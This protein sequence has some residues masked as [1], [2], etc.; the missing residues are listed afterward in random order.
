RMESGDYKGCTVI[1]LNDVKGLPDEFKGMKETIK[2]LI[3]SD[4]TPTY[5]AK[6]IAFHM[7]KFGII[8]NTFRFGTFIEKQPNGKPILET[9]SEG[10]EM[11]LANADMSINIIDVRQSY[12]QAVLKLAFKGIGRDDVADGIRHLAYGEVELE[13]G[14]LSGR[15]GT[16]IGFSADDLLAEARERSSKLIK[17][18]FNF[19]DEEQNRISAS[20][21]LAAIKFE[22]MRISPEKKIVFSWDRALNFEGNSGPYVQYMYARA[23]RILEQAGKADKAVKTDQLNTQEFALL[24]LLSKGHEIMEKA[25]REQRPNVITEYASELASGFSKFYEASPVLKAESGELKSL[26]LSITASVRETLGE[27]L[28]LLGIEPLERM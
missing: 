18:K 21:A 9:A 3:R 8:S 2:V 28:S 15:K 26:R 12:P 4:G 19:S 16:W 17:A 1:D 14:A 5:I 13:T 25:A 11:G 22:F 7:W 10:K 27:M 20:V 6:D 23:S 24:K